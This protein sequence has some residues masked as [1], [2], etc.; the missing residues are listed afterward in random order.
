MSHW[1]RSAILLIPMVVVYGCLGVLPLAAIVDLSLQDG[2][3]S[4]VRVMR[5][6]VFV[7]ILGNTLAISLI[8]TGVSVALGYL[9]ASAL[10]TC[11]GWLRAGLISVILFPFWTAVL[12]KNFAWIIVL[13]DAGVINSALQAIG[14][15]DSPIHLLYT[16]ASVIIGMVH[17]TLP[18]AV[19]SIYSVMVGIDGKLYRAAE[20]LG[21]SAFHTFFLITL[22]LTQA[23]IYAAAILV[24]IISLGFYITPVVLGGPSEMMLANLVDFYVNSIVDFRA[25]AALSIIILGM[26][27]AAVVVYQRLPRGGQYGTP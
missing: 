23:G 20:S 10:W 4:F 9:L 3:R 12:I 11:S 7:R 16:R 5:S 8:T 24:F 22:P 18:Y 17:Y 27:A 13:G 1:K 6:S 25:A 2:G 15:M 14:L 19:F 21:A 26:A